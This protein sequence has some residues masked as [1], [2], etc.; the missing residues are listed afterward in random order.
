MT[1]AL[2]GAKA[3]VNR[4]PTSGTSEQ[5]SGGDAPG[6]ISK[7]SGP[8]NSYLGP[9]VDQSELGGHAVVLKFQDQRMTS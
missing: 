5:E 9:Q 2:L 7:L 3:K 8:K 6:H 4:T 1:K